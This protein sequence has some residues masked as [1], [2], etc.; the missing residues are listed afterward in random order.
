MFDWYMVINVY[1]KGYIKQLSTLLSIMSTCSLVVDCAFK[2]FDMF[3]GDITLSTL[4]NF[5]WY[6]IFREFNMYNSLWEI[7]YIHIIGIQLFY[8]HLAITL[9]QWY[10]Q[11]PLIS[12]LL[13]FSP[14]NKL[15]T[16]TKQ[17]IW[18]PFTGTCH[19]ASPLKFNE[20][21]FFPMMLLSVLISR[22]VSGKFLAHWI[23]RI[24]TNTILA[25]FWHTNSI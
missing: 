20:T 1:L 19:T 25:Y 7:H 22:Y 9:I 11:P 10:N 17:D 6:I 15:L 8:L 21:D 4:L 12:S 23:N 5:T 16:K 3:S 13:F 14:Y 2:I 24:V 18:H